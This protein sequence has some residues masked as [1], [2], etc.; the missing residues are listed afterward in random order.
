[1]LVLPL[2]YGADYRATRSGL[3][4]TMK[5]YDYTAGAAL[6]KSTLTFDEFVAAMKSGLVILNVHTDAF[7]PGEISGKVAEG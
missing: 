3:R 7:H 2:P 1:V 5:D 6:L 4:V